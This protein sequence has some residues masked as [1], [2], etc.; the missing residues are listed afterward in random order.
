MVRIDHNGCD[1][2]GVFWINI[3]AEGI[4]L[5]VDVFVRSTEAIDDRIDIID[6]WSYLT[7]LLPDDNLSHPIDQNRNLNLNKP[8]H[9]NINIHARPLLMLLP[10]P[11][12][13][14]YAL[15]VPEITALILRHLPVDPLMQADISLPADQGSIVPL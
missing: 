3:R 13:I 14:D 1:Y 10:S 11:L 12:L 15:A 4:I 8:R 2:I 6:I 7:L 9:L 5:P